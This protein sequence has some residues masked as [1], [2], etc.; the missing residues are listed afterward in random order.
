MI[1]LIEF[2]PSY[3]ILRLLARH[4]LNFSDIDLWEIHEAFAAQ[5]LANV[6]A[7]SD[8]NWVRNIAGV[9]ANLGSFDW[10]RVNPNG[11]TVAIGQTSR[12]KADL[13]AIAK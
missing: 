6:A 11:D 1:S 8:R 3:G 13:R 2:R 5:V 10:D 7:F 4:G 9:D 12:K